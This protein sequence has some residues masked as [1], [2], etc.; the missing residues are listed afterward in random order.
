MQRLLSTM[1]KQGFVAR[2]S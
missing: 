1:K 2:V